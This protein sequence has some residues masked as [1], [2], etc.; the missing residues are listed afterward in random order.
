MMLAKF[1]SSKLTK[2]TENNNVDGEETATDDIRLAG[3]ASKER[4]KV[5][6][7]RGQSQGNVP[8]DVIRATVHPWTRE[9]KKFAFRNHES[10]Q[11][12]TIPS[13]VKTI[14]WKSFK[15]C[16]TLVELHLEAGVTKIENEAFQS[17]SCVT[18]SQKVDGAP[19]VLT[20][21][22]TVESIGW[23]AFAECTSL[24]HVCFPGL[25]LKS[26]PGH[27]FQNCTSLVQVQ[28]PHGLKLISIY[29]FAGCTS[30]ANIEF[31]DSLEELLG[32]AFERCASLLEISF[33]RAMEKIGAY[34]FAGCTDLVSVEFQEGA[35]PITIYDCA[36]GGCTSLSAVALPS[37]VELCFR[38]FDHCTSLLGVEFAPNCKLLYT[39]SCFHGCKSLVNVCLP[40]SVIDENDAFQEC[41]LLDDFA[42]CMKE[43]YSRF[44]VHQ[45]CYNSSTTRVDDLIRAL[46][47]TKMNEDEFGMT[48]FHVVAT[49]AHPRVEILE[50]LM[51]RYSMEI[52]CRRN[53][54][55]NTMM[56]YLLIHTSSKVVPLI[57]TV[58]RRSVLDELHRW[59]TTGKW[60]L[61]LSQALDAI[62]RL[63]GIDAAKR[64]SSFVYDSFFRDA[65]RVL[66]VE[67]I[68]LLELALWKMRIDLA[69]VEGDDSRQICRLQSRAGVLIE[70]VSEYLWNDETYC[71]TALSFFPVC[72]ANIS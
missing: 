69:Q 48:A 31:P 44:P 29:A 70:N 64:R 65:G 49:S 13:N 35:K 20:I 58:L 59:D 47:S 63:C 36:F 4:R 57:Q 15:G 18:G 19:S 26:L 67:L 12:I 24:A 40:A 66:R 55:G 23:W 46:D 34:S 38:V 43:R 56:D 32:H 61:I 9:I 2:K 8:L 6:V 60:E 25:G 33:P 68:S 14:G 16:S 37:T 41:W 53:D 3:S 17:C 11:S 71:S 45:V 62:P 42:G 5:F 7:Y 39:Y 1:L 10:L 52:L 21:P 51:D 28:L 54:W 27:V 22:K 50:C 30:L 72:S